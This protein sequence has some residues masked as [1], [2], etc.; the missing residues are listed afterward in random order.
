MGMERMKLTNLQNL[1]RQKSLTNKMEAQKLKFEQDRLSLEQKLREQE[2][3]N[4]DV[5]NK[6]SLLTAQNQH[7]LAQ[8]ERLKAD[9]LAKNEAMNVRIQKNEILHAEQKNDF[10]QEYKA[11]MSILQNEYAQIAKSCKV[12]EESMQ[13][14][15]NR[16]KQEMEQMFVEKMEILK[17]RIYREVR[18]EMQSEMDKECMKM[19]KMQER[20][21]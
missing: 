7:L 19:Y 17:K 11:K 9:I 3:A 21:Q 5:L 10:E 20:A 13:N 14:E 6:Q 15:L 8:N 18:E 16:K 1:S 12:Y 2:N 4:K